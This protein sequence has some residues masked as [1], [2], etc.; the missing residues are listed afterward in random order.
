MPTREFVVLSRT[1][2]DRTV[3][4]A[5]ERG[6]TPQPARRC[7]RAALAV[8]SRCVELSHPDAP[9]PVV[10]LQ[11]I[12]HVR[13]VGA[14]H[15]LNG[16]SWARVHDDPHRFVTTVDDCPVVAELVAALDAS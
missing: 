12:A 6:W 14:I 3:E 7:V 9:M 13:A 15:G 11:S 10:L 16:S 4:L 2:V 8:V 1:Q 5:G